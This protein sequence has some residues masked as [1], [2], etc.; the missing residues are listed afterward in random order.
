MTKS[1]SSFSVSSMAALGLF[2]L[3]PLAQA[4][5]KA[6][7]TQVMRNGRPVTIE[8]VST[9]ELLDFVQK[10]PALESLFRQNEV[11]YSCFLR[12][13]QALTWEQT[14]ILFDALAETQGETGSD[15]DKLY[16]GRI[17]VEY[18]ILYHFYTENRLSLSLDATVVISR[19]FPDPTAGDQAL[20]DYFYN[21]SPRS[22]A[23]TQKLID[24]L[25]SSRKA[26]I[27]AAVIDL[28]LSEAGKTLSPEDAIA[29][30][31]RLGQGYLINQKIEAYVRARDPKLT[32]DQLKWVLDSLDPVTNTPPQ[33]HDR[34]ETKDRMIRAWYGW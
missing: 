2:L 7:Q 22:L 14:K 15:N 10:V 24:A 3:A 17:V 31:K 20:Q 13:K 8:T 29:L 6:T 12:L 19:M 23:E 30:I 32:W 5:P 25:R 1:Y 26:E 27:M 34:R 16:Y 4:C 18:A 33:P 21:V 9:D 28:F 11:M